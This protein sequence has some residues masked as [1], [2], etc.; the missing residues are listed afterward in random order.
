MRARVY[1]CVSAVC[2]RVCVCVCVC[3]FVC[4]CACAHVRA[5]ARECV[6]REEYN[7]M[8]IYYLF[9]FYVYI[10]I[11]LVKRRV[12]TLV[13]EIGCCRNGSCYHHYYHSVD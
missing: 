5:C 4:V 3:V 12:L 9:K 1:L 8:F 2:V 13:G 11:G 10:F 6:W 7:I